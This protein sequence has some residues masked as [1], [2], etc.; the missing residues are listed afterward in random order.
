MTDRELLDLAAK[1]AGHQTKSDRLNVWLVED[2][3]SPVERWNPLADDSQALRLAVKLRICLEFTHCADDAPVIYCG[4][5]IERRNWPMVP[6][7]PD[8]NATT[9]RAIVMAAAEIGKTRSD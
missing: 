5:D 1:A 2:D 6:N 3:G 9:R 8:A 7:F 4:R